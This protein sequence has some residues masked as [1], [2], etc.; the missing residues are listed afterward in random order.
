MACFLAAFLGVEIYG[1]RLSFSIG[2]CPACF[3]AGGNRPDPSRLDTIRSLT[4][5]DEI[6]CQGCHRWRT[7]VG[8][9]LG[10]LLGDLLIM[11]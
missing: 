1:A 4:F 3:E 2:G 6:A 8:Y 11:L 10:Y 7:D 5:G 9:L